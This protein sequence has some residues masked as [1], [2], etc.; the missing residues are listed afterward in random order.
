[1]IAQSTEEMAAQL[2]QG[3]DAKGTRDDLMSLQAQAMASGTFGFGVGPL[4]QMDM[5]SACGGWRNFSKGDSKGKEPRQPI[6]AEQR[7]YTGIIKSYDA[8]KRNGRIECEEIRRETG[9]DVY[10]FNEVLSRGHAGVGDVVVF[11]LHQSQRGQL[12]ASSPMVRTATHLGYAQT[13]IYRSGGLCDRSTEGGT[14]DCYECKRIFGR[15][16]RVPKDLA[17]ELVFGRRCAFN[18]YMNQEGNIYVVSVKEVDERYVPPSGDLSTSYTMP[19]YVPMDRN[20]M[21]QQWKGQQQQANDA[22]GGWGSQATPVAPPEIPDKPEKGK[23]KGTSKGKE[24]KGKN[25][26]KMA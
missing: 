22:G 23:G 11:A 6:I 24:G 12:Q 14:I 26:A 10:V 16:A 5:S 19:G 2:Q 13:G 20:N 9:N 8:V 1:M 21:V 15:E 25:S 7:I 4:G 18:A 3:G 17:K